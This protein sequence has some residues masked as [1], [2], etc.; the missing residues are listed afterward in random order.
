MIKIMHIRILV[1]FILLLHTACSSDSDQ[2]L[3]YALKFAGENR[4][5]LE[6]VLSHYAEEPEKLAAAR[7]LIENMPYH[8]G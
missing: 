7:F 4:V 5:E 8:Y 2:R 3:D 6:K 1:F